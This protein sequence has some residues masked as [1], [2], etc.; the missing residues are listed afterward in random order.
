MW[1]L[2]KGS[3]AM[4]ENWMLHRDLKPAN[5]LVVGQGP[6]SG[7]LK[8]ADFGLAR[9]SRLWHKSCVPCQHVR[10]HTAVTSF[11]LCK[12]S[13]GQSSLGAIE[14]RSRSAPTFPTHTH[15]AQD[16]HLF[17]LC[18]HPARWRAWT[19]VGYC[20]SSGQDARW[21]A[22]CT[23]YQVQQGQGILGHVGYFKDPCGHSPAMG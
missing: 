13:T 3:N 11:V 5:I 17:W 22:A 19:P 7:T 23:V 14:R 12:F 1:Q 20:K 18:L 15:F 8:I 16:I 6:E 9:Y 2:L 10:A 21:W 4:H